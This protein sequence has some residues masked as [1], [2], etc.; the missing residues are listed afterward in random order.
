MRFSMAERSSIIYRH[1]T[2][3]ILI[4]NPSWLTRFNI[5]GYKKLYTEM[6][7]ALFA[8]LISIC[9]LYNSTILIVFNGPTQTQ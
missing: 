6:D 5:L 9:D 1:K 2:I 7:I 4:E 3:S 8:E